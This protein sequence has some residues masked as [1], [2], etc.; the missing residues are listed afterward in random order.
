MRTLP[1]T[2]GLAALLAAGLLAAC[3]EDERNPVGADLL[4]PPGDSIQEVV[5]EPAEAETFLTATSDRGFGTLLI[6][7]H[8]LPAPAGFESRILLRFALALADTAR[9][10]VAVD[11]A[12]VRFTADSLAPDSVRFR[13]HRVT[14]SWVEAEVS[15]EERSFD[16]PWSVAGGAFDPVPLVEGV[17]AGDSATF[18]VPDSLAQRWLDDPEANDGLLLLL[19]TPEAFARLIAASTTGLGDERGPRLRLFV[20]VNDS[21]S[22]SNVIATADAFITLFQGAILPG[23]AAGNEPL[24]RS[25]LRFDLGPI[26]ADAS[27]NLAELRLVPRQVVSP[28]DS[29]Q[30]E[31]R[32][33]VSP[34]LGGAT[35]F[36]TTLLGVAAVRPDSGVTFSGPALAGLVRTWQADSSLNLGLG[37]QAQRRFGNLGFAVY[38]GPDAP[39]AD[40]PRLRIIFTPSLQ[41]DLGRGA[42]N[43]SAP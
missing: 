32:R 36:S 40:R 5:L 11:S 28:V 4:P 33:V 31:F 12:E 10:P 24:F 27:I 23:L 26:P 13:L 18:A 21:S 29:L 7:A 9:G 14:E 35:V 1:W 25:L 37:L 42:P 17:L 20:T 16:L 41:P 39:P 43:R 38:A 6:A 22:V 2:S 19:E 30:L 3:S 8:E 15:W 34:F